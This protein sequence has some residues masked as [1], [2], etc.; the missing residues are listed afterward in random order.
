LWQD[1]ERLQATAWRLKQVQIENADAAKVMRQF[2]T[3]QTLFYVDP[4]YVPDTRNKS[5]DHHAYRF[6]LDEDGHRNLARSL[7]ELEGL[8]I[9]SGYPSQLYTELFADW[10]CHTAQ[11]RTQNPNK[12]A[13]EC[14][15]L[16]PR[17]VAALGGRQLTFHMGGVNP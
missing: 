3:S 2:D 10:P 16:S 9:L 5:W 12:Q 4:P 6:E 15:W 17:T 14:V 7:H 13:T 11:S 8:V 1:T